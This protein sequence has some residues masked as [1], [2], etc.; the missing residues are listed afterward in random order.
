MDDQHSPRLR[1][2]PEGAR[3]A[4]T[5][6]L[7]V[8]TVLAVV[9]VPSDLM[10]SG[11]HDMALLAV[12]IWLQVLARWLQHFAPRYVRGAELVGA[13]LIGAG[14]YAGLVAR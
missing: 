8:A 5:F 14:L 3:R 11:P 12:G 4:D 1:S 6:L 10:A 9:A 7:V 13:I 2:I